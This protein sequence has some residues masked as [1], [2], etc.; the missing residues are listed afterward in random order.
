MTSQADGSK[1]CNSPDIIKVSNAIGSQY[2]FLIGSK[3]NEQ[4]ID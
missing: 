4:E 1:G 2:L 3:S